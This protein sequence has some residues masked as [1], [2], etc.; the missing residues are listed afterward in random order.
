MG[1]YK[2]NVACWGYNFILWYE[3]S[4]NWKR[5]TEISSINKGSLKVQTG[6]Q[7][8]FKKREE[9][10]ALCWQDYLWIQTSILMLKF[11]RIW[12]EWTQIWIE[13]GGSCW[14]IAKL[15]QQRHSWEIFDNDTKEREQ[16]FI[17]PWRW[18]SFKSMMT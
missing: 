12:S 6:F 16:E 3:D 9:F 15:W 10:K 8:F 18:W 7:A 13:D 2:F 4:V 11:L 5:K 17:D 14:T 1:S